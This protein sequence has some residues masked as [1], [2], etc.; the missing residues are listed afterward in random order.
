M[1]CARYF[2]REGEDIPWDKAEV[3]TLRE[4][5][6]GG[7]G[8]KPTLFRMLWTDDAM[9]FRFDCA[10]DKAVA[11]LTKFNDDLFDEDV[12]EVFITDGDRR[13]YQEFE[14]APNGN[15][16]HLDIK[17]TMRGFFFKKKRK[18]DEYFRRIE[19]DGENWTAEFA[20]PF[21]H[22]RRP[23]RAGEEWLMNAHRCDLKADGVEQ[24]LYAL[25]PTFFTTYHRPKYFVPVRFEKGE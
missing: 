8:K 12:A 20:V 11:T 17:N 10:D 1:V 18:K 24:D 9:W 16:M 4:N 13:K 22:F 25:N 6:R 23:P 5:V 7:E 21:V 2:R 14:V 15:G 3:Y 19:K